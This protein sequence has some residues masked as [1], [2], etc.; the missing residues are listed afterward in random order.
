[1]SKIRDINQIEVRILDKVYNIQSAEEKK[2]RRVADYLNA[3]FARLKTGMPGR[4]AID[5]TVMVAFQAASDYFDALEE[6]ERL[7]T[8]VESR[9]AALTAKIDKNL[10]GF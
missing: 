7:K 5:L 2:V 10:P 9:A 8:E 1:M 3:N 4:N 6:L